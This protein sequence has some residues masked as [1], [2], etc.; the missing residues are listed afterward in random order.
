MRNLVTT[1]RRDTGDLLLTP[2]KCRCRTC[3]EC[4]GWMGT[5]LRM[6]M[7]AK[8]DQFARPALLSL[9]VDRDGHTVAGR[10]RAH[11]RLR[12]AP[13]TPTGTSPTSPAS[14]G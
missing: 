10:C 1:S 12:L 14:P 13:G 4:A 9:T 5:R 8:A 6:R 2:H 11:R 7:L 3:R